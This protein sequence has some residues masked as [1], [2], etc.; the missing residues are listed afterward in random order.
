MLTL[1]YIPKKIRCERRAPRSKIR[2]L[3][4]KKEAPRNR[5]LLLSKKKIQ[6][7]HKKDPRSTTTKK[8]EKMI[9]QS[10]ML[11]VYNIIYN[12]LIKNNYTVDD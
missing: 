4:K 6:K 5:L 1:F 3:H 12:T 11:F 9:Y 2:M 10:L 8:E 7:K